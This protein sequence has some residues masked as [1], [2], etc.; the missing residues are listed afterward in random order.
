MMRPV[1]LTHALKRLAVVF[2]TLV[3]MD[4]CSKGSP[5]STDFSPGCWTYCPPSRP[6]GDYLGYHWGEFALVSMDGSLDGQNDAGTWVPPVRLVIRDTP[7]GEVWV[8][9]DTVWVTDNPADP[10][11]ASGL[12]CRSATTLRIDSASVQRTVRESRSAPC[13][14]SGYLYYEHSAL[15]YSTFFADTLPVIIDAGVAGNAAMRTIGA[16]SVS[17]EVSSSRSKVW[18]YKPTGR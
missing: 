9:A 7:A 11:H 17:T 4:G 1:V 2:L 5:T 6:W 16:F 18:H 14:W 12:Q 3:A 10:A 15:R 13:S 8:T